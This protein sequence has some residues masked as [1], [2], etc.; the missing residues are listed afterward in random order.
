MNLFP[1]MQRTHQ[2]SASASR[3]RRQRRQRPGLESLEGR[4][5]LS[6]GA[7]FFVNTPSVN[8][9]DQVASANATNASG[10]SVVA[11]EGVLSSTDH[12]IYAQ[13]YNANGSPRGPE[14]TVA[15]S[16]LDH[17]AAEVAMDNNG[18]FVVA[19][20]EGPANNSTIVAKRYNNQGQ[21]IGGQVADVSIGGGEFDPSVA[22]D[23]VGDF[24]I[25]YTVT[26]VPGTIQTDVV[27]RR[28]DSSGNFLQPLFVGAESVPGF[29]SESKVAMDQG[30][31]IATSGRISSRR[32]NWQTSRTTA[33]S[34]P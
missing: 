9:H 23:S 7:P 27:A 28:F 20:M 8:V 13:M 17:N 21:Q 30:G 15:S 4:Q 33:A 11:W 19:Y 29:A 2:P 6:L 12:A 3:V 1:R 31:D 32:S 24:V 25:S 16:N 18:D 26:L 22:M 14:I 10:M 34:L 5:L